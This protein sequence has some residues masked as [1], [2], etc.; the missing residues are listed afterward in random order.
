MDD[1]AYFDEPREP[2]G[3]LREISWDGPEHYHVDR[4]PDWFWMLGIVVLAFAVAMVI[5]GNVLFGIIIL[6]AGGAVALLAM[7]GPRII[8]HSISVRGIRLGNDFYPYSKL[9]AYRI[10]EEHPRGAHL[11]IQASDMFTPLLTFPIPED[12]IDEIEDIIATK[13]PEE[14]LEEP[15]S[16][17]LLE[18][19]GF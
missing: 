4:S 18:I 10:D 16:H 14:H 2:S 8:T 9:S 17:R 5:F 13:L 1:E 7:K 3:R 11:L 12:A 15:I 19:L 6:L